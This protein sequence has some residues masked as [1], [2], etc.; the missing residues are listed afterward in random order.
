MINGYHSA[1]EAN[2]AD[3]PEVTDDDSAQGLITD[4]VGDLDDVESAIDDVDY[5]KALEELDD[6]LEKLTAVRVYINGK[7][8]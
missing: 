6:V 7:V 1:G 8:E 5:V 4:A 3:K 2:M